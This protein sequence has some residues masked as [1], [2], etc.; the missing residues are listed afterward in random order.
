MEDDV[1]GARFPLGHLLDMGQEGDDAGLAGILL[2][3]RRRR[4]RLLVAMSVLVFVACGGVAGGVIIGEAHPKAVTTV[5]PVPSVSIRSSVG[6]LRWVRFADPDASLSLPTTASTGLIGVVADGSVLRMGE[7]HRLSV[8]SSGGARLRLF[9][10]RPPSNAVS[11]PHFE[12]ASSTGS[13]TGPGT[14]HIDHFIVVEVSGRQ[15]VG[16]AVLP[17][18]KLADGKEPSALGVSIIGRPEHDPVVVVIALT[19]RRDESV[20]LWEGPRKESTRSRNRI[21]VLVLPAHPKKQLVIAI[22]G[23]RGFRVPDTFRDAGLF[24]EPVGACPLVGTTPG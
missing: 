1:T 12:A 9:T 2:R 19:M 14:C 8:R 17:V 23:R 24:A 21:A 18:P 16:S 3:Y 4:R 22:G 13:A 5:S 10:A 6:G 20:T 7:L 11:V 15:F